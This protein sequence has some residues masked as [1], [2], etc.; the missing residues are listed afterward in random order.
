MRF[1]RFAPLPA[2]ALVATAGCTDRV[3]TSAV[4]PASIGNDVAQTVQFDASHLPATIS[5]ANLRAII[6]RER[7]AQVHARAVGFTGSMSTVL[8]AAQNPV[9]VVPG[10]ISNGT[11]MLGITPEGALNVEA[12][13]PS[14]TPDR[15][16][17]DS[18][19]T[20]VGL[21]YVPTNTA[22]IESGCTCEGWGVGDAI[23][24]VHGG[25]NTAYDSD[26]GYAYRDEVV[27]AEVDQFVSTATTAFSRTHVGSTFSVTHE[28]IP[29]PV[30]SLYQLTVTIANV[31]AAP[32]HALYR[33]TIDWDIEPNPFD[34]YVTLH[35]GVAPQVLRMT[36][37]PFAGTNPLRVEIFNP[38]LTQPVLVNTDVVN[39]GPADLGALFDFDFGTLAPGEA[40]VFRAYYGAATTPDAALAA[41][42]A[43]GAADTYTLARG[44]DRSGGGSAIGQLTFMLGFKDLTS[45]PIRLLP[46]TVSAVIPPPNAQG[47]YTGSPALSWSVA[48]NG[49]AIARTAGCEAHTIDQNTAGT[50]YTC[51]ATDAAGLTTVTSVTVRRDATV[52]A[53]SASVSGTPTNGWY[54][55]SPTV[56][57]L[58]SGTAAPSGLTTTGCAATT[59]VADTPASGTTFTCTATTG[60]GVA[61]SATTVVKRDGTAPT[62]LLAGPS[63]QVGGSSSISITCVASDALSGIATVTG[64]AP[65]SGVAL[66]LGAG[67]VTRTAT[68]TDRAGNTGSATLTFNITVSTA[69]LCTVTKLWVDNAGIKTALCRILAAAESALSRGQTLVGRRI[70]GEY[71]VAVRAVSPRFLSAAHA[72][73]LVNAARSLG[74]IEP[75]ARGK[76]A[77]DGSDD[78]GD[79]D[80]RKRDR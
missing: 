63:G 66:L 7:L 49:S 40:K 30:P 52:P 46:P 28:Y 50:T 26:P 53:V 23:T 13:Y 41:L 31:S 48:G 33:R 37:S 74:A 68:A 78:A 2:I 4:A 43:V 19:V 65:F 9:G 18:A 38:F 51:S 62:V 47:W 32:V 70:L 71:V 73:A 58:V 64:C 8:V 6:A 34:E 57:F 20:V 75:V 11:I 16:R 77:G 42:T 80:E 22:S 10:V 25:R 60:A 24:G 12:N 79:D 14:S 5:S 69:D 17:L 27:R 72:D 56:S 1:C 76:H 15:S 45:A 21:R 61:A 35:R 29:S 59:I 55:A 54:R 44:H 3:P 36:D 39:E 67:P